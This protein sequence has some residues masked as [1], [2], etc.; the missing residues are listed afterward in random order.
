MFQEIKTEGNLNFVCC[1]TVILLHLV[2]V[3]TLRVSEAQVVP[4][5]PFTRC[6]VVERR[7]PLTQPNLVPNSSRFSNPDVVTLQQLWA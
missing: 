5:T 1:N 6:I 7:L 2:P 4:A 3:Y